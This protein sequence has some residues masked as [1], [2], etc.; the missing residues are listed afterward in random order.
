MTD[1]MI[2]GWVAIGLAVVITLVRV[3]IQVYLM[4]KGRDGDDAKY[5]RQQ[6]TFVAV[7]FIFGFMAAAG[8]ADEVLPKVVELVTSWGG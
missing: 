5:S 6:I 3:A 8:I 2:M 1:L 7:L 4:V